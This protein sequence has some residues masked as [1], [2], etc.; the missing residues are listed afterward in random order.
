MFLMPGLIIAFYITGTPLGEARRAGMEAYLRNHQQV[1][2]ALAPSFGTCFSIFI[3]VPPYHPMFF[4]FFEVFP[5]FAVA[6]SG[7]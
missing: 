6:H 7:H 4:C 5:A 2:V 1:C 3:G